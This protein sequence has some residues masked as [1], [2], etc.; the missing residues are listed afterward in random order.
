[1]ACTYHAPISRSISKNYKSSIAF[2]N[3]DAS[4]IFF[5]KNDTH[6]CTAV[7]P[8]YNSHH[9]CWNQETID[10]DS[11]PKRARTP[12]TDHAEVIGKQPSPIH[13][14]DHLGEQATNSQAIHRLWTLNFPPV[15]Q[16][17]TTSSIQTG[18][19]LAADKVWKANRQASLQADIRLPYN[20]AL[21]IASL[22]PLHQ[23]C[24]SRLYQVKTLVSI[25][26]RID[27]NN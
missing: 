8:R 10:R 19:E 20:A 13:V 5:L 4:T 23:L 6:I 9:N 21:L 26:T 3:W 25:R 27:Q 11:T 17:P 2:Q 24:S 18:G 7:G 16:N 12:Q 15:Q 1:M 22:L 14:I